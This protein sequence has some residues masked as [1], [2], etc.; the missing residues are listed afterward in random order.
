MSLNKFWDADD[1]LM[2]NE[3]I[4]STLDMDIIGLDLTDKSG[5]IYNKDKEI[6]EGSKLE[7]PLWLTLTL[8]KMNNSITIRQPKYLTDKY[9]NQ[10]QADPVIV[11]FKAKNPYLYDIVM[12]LI[13]YLDEE[14][15]WPKCYGEVFYKRF[16]HLLKNSSNIVYENQSLMKILAWKE[17]NFYDKIVRINKNIRF[18]LDNYENNNK[19]LDE[20][21]EAKKLNQKRKK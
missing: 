15:K 6:K 21:I 7:A 10:L 13:P 8:R 12:H 2:S 5:N 18:Y 3:I 16:L 1:L 9:Y 14:N 20:L 19:N 17:K 11:N 4:T